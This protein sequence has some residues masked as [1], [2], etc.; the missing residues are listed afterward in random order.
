[1]SECP[2]ED[3]WLG[4]L[5]A[6]SAISP[7]DG[8]LEAHLVC[9]GVCRDLVGILA[10][11][12]PSVQREPSASQSTSAREDSKAQAPDSR[13]GTLVA[14]KWLVEAFLGAGGMGRV[15]RAR[16]RNG[17]PVAIKFLHPEL[18]ARADVV[19]RFRREGYSANRV[20]HPAVVRVLDDGEDGGP[21]L[22][23]ELLDGRSCSSVVREDGPRATGEALRIVEVVGQALAVAHREGIVHRDVKPDNV[24][25]LADGSVR[26]LDFGLAAVRDPVAEGSITAD[27]TTM[28]T[29]GYMPPEQA[30]G[31]NSA[32]GPASDVWSLAATCVSLVAGRPIHQ[33]RT[34]AEQLAFAV[35]KKVPPVRSFR[36]GF[37]RAVE[38][39]LDRAL[40]FDPSARPVDAGA[41]VSE[42]SKARARRGSVPS[43]RIVTFGAFTVVGAVAMI[44]TEIF[45]RE[46]SAPMSVA[47]VRSV[48]GEIVEKNA[49]VVA[50]PPPVASLESPSKTDRETPSPTASSKA[51][52]SSSEPRA[53]I[54]PA[55]RRAPV[56]ASIDA[57][58]AA[59][60][61]V[62]RDPLAPRF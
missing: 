17:H 30:R 40:S 9:C 20:A 48:D 8:A 23:M 55:V 25:L 52:S 16:H 26:L 5:D 58:P 62:A 61:V 14:D 13:I 45:G 53:R 35:T 28:G 29:V 60:P 46:E 6:P 10:K 33:G 24:F 51:S 42:L 2:D 50:A 54:R 56:D 38:A 27:G 59:A 12:L 39:V 44:G 41:F 22:V 37:S 36:L 43:K 3:A 19:R 15:Y 57:P 49:S 31:E 4:F 1:M 47:P 34:P 11:D 32:V 21:F 7:R 18:T